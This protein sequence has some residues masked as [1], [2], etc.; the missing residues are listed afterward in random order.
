[1]HSHRY[2]DAKHK[3]TLKQTGT[4]ARTHTHTPTHTLSPAGQLSV[5]WALLSWDSMMKCVE[6]S[7]ERKVL[8]GQWC[9]TGDI[10]EV[11]P[12]QPSLTATTLLDMGAGVVLSR[13]GSVEAEDVSVHHLSVCVCACVHETV[14]Y[15]AIFFSFGVCACV[16]TLTVS[17]HFHSDYLIPRRAA[18]ATQVVPGNQDKSRCARS[19]SR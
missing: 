3:R 4:H 10:R 19:A 6:T 18:L 12:G 7:G 5:M 2:C 8:P 15:R 11:V 17:P 13:H 16:W 9:V 14:T 1:M